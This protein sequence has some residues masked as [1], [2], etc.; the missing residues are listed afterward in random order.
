MLS[1][2]YRL[3]MLSRWTTLNS[4]SLSKVLC[5]LCTFPPPPSMT[6]SVQNMETSSQNLLFY[7]LQC[8]FPNSEG[9]YFHMSNISIIVFKFF[10]FGHGYFFFY[11]KKLFS[12]PSITQCMYVEIDNIH[13][14]V[15]AMQ[16]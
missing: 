1:P 4:F 6:H 3:Q 12:N 14:W 11:C 10:D 16:F 15:S 5:I 9:K 8:F 2:I 13:Q 7:T